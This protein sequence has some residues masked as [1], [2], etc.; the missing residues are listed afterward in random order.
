MQPFQS[1]RCN[2]RASSSS[3]MSGAG[4]G[5]NRFVPPSTKGG[6]SERSE[7]EGGWPPWRPSRAHLGQSR[8][9]CRS[10]RPT[11]S[12]RQVG[13]LPILDAATPVPI[14]APAHVDP[15]PRRKWPWALA[16][17]IVLLVTLA[18]IRGDAPRTVLVTDG[19]ISPLPAAEETAVPPGAS[20]YIEID[21]TS[22]ESLEV[23]DWD[24]CVVHDH[25]GLERIDDFLYE[26]TLA[27]AEAIAAQGV[28]DWGVSPVSV[29]S[30]VIPGQ[31]GGIYDPNNGSITLDEPLMAWS[32]IHEL[33][34]HI[35]TEQHPQVVEGHGA[36][37][38]ATLESL[39][40]GS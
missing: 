13:S 17:L 29:G 7:V 9:I 25:V 24:Y 21:P 16:G 30:R 22:S 10:V 5:P 35:V 6:P 3:C 2:R 37:F 23:C 40:G 36:E 32:L 15:Q 8:T 34:H 12:D 38:L 27:E 19:A 1:A 26:I 18:A 14:P 39:A 28:E 4:T 11:E 33:A 31:T 20:P